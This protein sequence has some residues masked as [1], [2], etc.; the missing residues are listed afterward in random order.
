MSCDLADGCVSQIR[1]QV[2][3][4]IRNRSIEGLGRKHDWKIS[5]YMD[6]PQENETRFGLLG[7]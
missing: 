6:K 3:E 4:V 7:H 5:V 1:R 2:P